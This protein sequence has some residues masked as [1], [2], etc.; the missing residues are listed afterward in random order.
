MSYNF[1]LLQILIVTIDSLSVPDCLMDNMIRSPHRVYQVEQD[2]CWFWVYSRYLWPEFRSK[3]LSH[4]TSPTIFIICST[5]CSP[6]MLAIR[7]LILSTAFVKIKTLELKPH[8]YLEFPCSNLKIKVDRGICETN[9]CWENLM[10]AKTGLLGR[11]RPSLDGG[12]R[13]TKSEGGLTPS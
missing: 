10:S 12:R 8:K 6:N 3:T 5:I 4:K 7:I 11:G 2:Y 13:R 1:F 9:Y